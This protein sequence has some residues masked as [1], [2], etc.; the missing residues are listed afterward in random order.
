VSKH[1]SRFVWLIVQNCGL[2]DPQRHK[3][4][5]SCP[6]TDCS[7]EVI[8]DGVGRGVVK[9]CLGLALCWSSGLC[10]IL[11][12]LLGGLASLVPAPVAS[13]GCSSAGYGLYYPFLFS[14]YWG[15]TDVF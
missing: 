11:L 7:H 4:P 13:F 14:G 2:K 10:H 6:G 12:C 3:Y 5:E 8:M 15:L 1:P 9:Q